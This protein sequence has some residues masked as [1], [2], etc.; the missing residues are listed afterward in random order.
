MKTYRHSRVGGNPALLKLVTIPLSFRART[1]NQL[2]KLL[3][4]LFAVFGLMIFFAISG[5][6]DGTPNDSCNGEQIS[7]LHSISATITRNEIGTLYDGVGTDDDDDYYYFTPGIAGTLTYSYTSDE[8]TDLRIQV[9]GTCSDSGTR[10]LNNGTSV[11]GSLAVLSTNTVYIRIKREQDSATTNYS[12]NMTFTVAAP[13]PEINVVGVADNGTDTSFGSTAVGGGF[14]DKIYTIQNLGTATL[15]IGVPTV[16]GD[17]TLTNLSAAFIAP[18]ASATFTVR[19]DPSAAGTRTGTVSFA[20]DD[21]NENPY[22]F[23]ISGIGFVPD[24]IN[25]TY[26]TGVGTTLT[27]NAAAGVLSNDTGVG[28]SV[29]S[30]TAPTSGSVAVNTDGSFTYTPASGF[31]GM[32]TF[33]YTMTDSVVS[34]TATVAITINTVYDNLHAF[35]RINPENTRYIRGNYAIA[36]NTVTCLTA[37]TSGYAGVNDACHGMTDYSDHT[38]NERVNKYIDIDSDGGTWN[39]TSSYITLPAT[40]DPSAGQGI[41]WA[42]LFWQGRISNNDDYVKH[43]AVENGASFTYTETKNAATINLNNT[44]ANKI[45]LKVDTGSYVDTQASTVYKSEAGGDVTYAAFS[46][47][48]S[49]L[50]SSNLQD[51]KHIFTVANL[52]TEEGRES[53]PGLFG[54]WSLVV[55]Y[56]EDIDG[57]TRN[58][59][60]YSGFD[61]VAE[62]SA[63]F[64][65][66]GLKLPTSGAVHANLSLFAGEGETL[67]SPDSVKISADGTNYDYMPG[68]VNNENIFDAVFSNINRD[69]V[70]G[71]ANDLAINNNGVD[72][73]TFNVSAL[74]TTYRDANPNLD[75]MYIQWSSGNDYITPSMLAFATELYEPKLCYDY[76]LKQDGRYLTVD[77][78]NPIAH[79]QQGVSSSPLELLVYLRNKEADIAADGISIKADVNASRFSYTMTNPIYVSNPNGSGLI[80]RGIPASNS[81]ENCVYS[82]ASGNG[83]GDLGCIS[84][85]PYSSS[86]IDDDVLRIRKGNGSLGSEEYIYTKFI[87]K[88]EQISGVFSDINESLGLSLDYYIHV[89]TVTIP[90]SDYILGGPNLQMCTS[91]SAYLPTWGLFNVVQHGQVQNNLKTQI[92]RKPFDV[93]VIYD[94]VIS[95]GVNDA[96]SSTVNTTV[97]VEMIDVDSFGDLNASCANPDAGVSE[98][99]IVPI[100]FTPNPAPAYQTLVTSQDSSYHNFALK[101][102]HIVYGILPRLMER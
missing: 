71:K 23:S 74:V 81:P 94:Q 85:L 102:V 58:L 21:S 84:S 35:D 59:S 25:D 50:Q 12:L 93:D 99:I 45:K 9:G 39:S 67:Y 60:V 7:E 6:S 73:D 2:L 83:I 3:S 32:A 52:T 30:F 10:Y 49:I 48:T 89:G 95:T 28:I 88:P 79:I 64:P 78:T 90:Y 16:T 26:S 100:A 65:I 70:T 68:A 31:T 66:S 75:T 69:A 19:F 51:G 29:T 42:G 22:N 44:N 11:S 57:K 86:T 5:W 55:I 96:P 15:T 72:V 46:D 54:G 56:A 80:D 27:V 37:L 13:A 91:S 36:G 87:L 24:A 76:S 63:A 33:T 101:T 61:R 1:R 77:R 62:P 34:D 40:Y 8:D 38:S 41:L 17:F 97:Q 92:A 47:V 53:S 43:Y 18:S 14:I 98:P 20:N 4:R 82:T